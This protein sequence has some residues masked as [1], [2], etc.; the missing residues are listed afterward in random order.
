[1]LSGRLITEMQPRGP[2]RRPLTG[3]REATEAVWRA[4][5]G[6]TAATLLGSLRGGAVAPPPATIRKTQPQSKR[7]RVR[8]ASA[9]PAIVLA[10]PARI[11]EQVF[12]ALSRL[13]L[14][15]QQTE[16]IDAGTMA[17][18][19]DP[20]A[21]VVLALQEIDEVRRKQISRLAA[22][23]VSRR[24]PVLVATRK[25]GDARF[26][27]ALYKAGVTAIFRWP[28]ESGLLV[29]AV[30]PLLRLPL[31]RAR[32]AD[33]ALERA[34]LTR[35]RASP[36]PPAPSL[37][38]VAMEGWVYLAG[39][40]GALWQVDELLAVVR[41]TPGVRGAFDR[42]MQAVPPPV[43]NDRLRRSVRRAIEQLHGVDASTLSIRCDAGHV[44]IAGSV[45]DKTSLERLGQTIRHLH[46]VGAL[47][48]LAT[49]AP[50]AQ[51]RDAA[52]AR[53]AQH[54]LRAY[55]PGMRLRVASFG[56]TLVLEGQ[57]DTSEKRHSTEVLVARLPGVRRVVNKLRTVD[58]AGG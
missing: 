58:G 23:C 44:T 55:Y 43:P 37:R 56:G 47:E 2:L 46:G 42:G 45:D 36:T 53:Q 21:A 13:P 20:P 54:T 8:S 3:I 27:R 26:L 52:I 38:L 9:T 57:V 22:D 31:P 16:A 11:R 19:T 49:I 6:N 41:A 39:T 32:G 51:R 25:L 18:C 1:M 40:L 28:A 7:Q 15:V 4:G 14:D 35:L 33:A 10:G 48:L 17:G 29:D 5:T 30:R 12:M 50:S 34:V 24:I